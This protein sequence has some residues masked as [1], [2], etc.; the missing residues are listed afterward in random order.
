M[1]ASNVSPTTKS[2]RKINLKITH[3]TIHLYPLLILRL[4]YKQNQL[5]TSIYN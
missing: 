4:T 3:G 2:D 1:I 5:F